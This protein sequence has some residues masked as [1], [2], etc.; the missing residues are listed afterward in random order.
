MNGFIF[1]MDNTLLQSNIDFYKMKKAVFTYLKVEGVLCTDL[2]WEHKTA[3]QLIEMGRKHPHFFHHEQKI[4]Q[5]ITEI[6]AEGM[7]GATLSP[8]AAAMLRRLRTDG[9]CLTILTNN[10]H[11]AALQVL[12]ELAVADY[13]D[14]I[15]GREQMSELKPSP[16]GVFAI[17]ERFPHIPKERWVLIGDSWI[18]GKAAN[19][20]GVAFLAYQ[21]DLEKLKRNQVYCM[22]HL[23][24]LSEI[25]N[26]F[27]G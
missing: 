20:A 1:D 27:P 16:S 23:N 13:F 10:A 17:L 12:Q 15:A 24:T 18:D 4:W 11:K 9:H 5:L 2:D 19:E 8:D 14:Y 25:P 21:A 6:E 7:L 26:R 3:S 22:A